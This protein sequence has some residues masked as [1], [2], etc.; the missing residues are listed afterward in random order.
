[1]NALVLKP[2][3]GLCPWC[4]GHTW[5]LRGRG[6]HAWV[7]AEHALLQLNALASAETLLP[8]VVQEGRRR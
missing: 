4:G 6:L 2:G 8:G 7:C 1:M 3:F 5:V